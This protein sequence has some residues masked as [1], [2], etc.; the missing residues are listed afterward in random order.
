MV[1]GGRGMRTLLDTLPVNACV[2]VDGGDCA[3]PAT[4]PESLIANAFEVVHPRSS[5]TTEL[6]EVVAMNAWNVM[7]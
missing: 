6:P 2:S 1:P 4:W 5:G 7:P 3:T